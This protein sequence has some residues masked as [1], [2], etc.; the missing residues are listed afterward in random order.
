MSEHI[1]C[2]ALRNKD[3]AIICGAKHYDEVMCKQIESSTLN[4]DDT[5]QGFINQQGKFLTRYEAWIV[6]SNN[7]QIKRR[8]GGD[9]KRLFS[10]NLY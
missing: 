8:V 3:G 7:G 4:W 10:E 2:A 5:E 9:R 6:A 1:V